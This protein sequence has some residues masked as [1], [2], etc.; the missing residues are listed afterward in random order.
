MERFPD[1]ITGESFYQKE[2]PDYFPDW[3]HRAS[4]PYHHK[5]VSQFQVVCD[6]PVTL[7]YLADQGCITPHTWLSRS[8]HLRRPDKMILDLDPPGDDFAPVR[9]VA[10]MVRDVLEGVGLRPSVMTTGSRG[11][12]V[13]VPIVPSLEFGRV[14]T[15]AESVA[16]IL[17]ERHPDLVT[18][19]IRK[20][21]RGN[22]IFIDALRNGYGATSAPPYAVRPKPGAPVATPLEW[23]ELEDP[24]IHSRS[25][26]ILNLFERL[27][28]KGD[29]WKGF[30]DN[31][32][33]LEDV[34]QDLRKKR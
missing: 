7:V 3:I 31:G 24:Q 17:A 9:T 32:Q 10:S 33:P 34:I 18:D 2:I 29:L 14:R 19:E 4:I 15:F 12:H 26:T 16:G 11:V 23:K 28:Q 21:K 22:R 25:F 6:S 8:T 13:V 30:H 1:G 20:E 27:V 5:G